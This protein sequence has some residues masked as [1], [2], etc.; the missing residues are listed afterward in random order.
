[1]ARLARHELT[2]VVACYLLAAIA[3]TALLWKDPASRIVAGNPGDPDQAAWW[4]RYAAEAVAHWRLPALITTA[5]NAPDGVNVMW[6]PSLLA[7]GVALSPVTLLF[8]PQV[9]LNVLLTVGFAGSA[10]SLYWVLRQ[11]RVG[12]VAAVVGGLAYGFSPA[13]AQSAVG[14]YDLQFAV[15]PPLIAHFTAWLLTGRAN[16]ERYGPLRTGA[17][18]GLVTALQ[19]LSCEELLFNVVL[20]IAV[21]LV[22]AGVSRVRSVRGWMDREALLGLASG[23]MTAVGVLILIA[24]Y[25]LLTQFAGPLAQHGSFYA[26]DYFKND[27]DGLIQ[28]SRLM[29]VHTRGSVAF[30]DQFGGGPSE[31]LGYLGWPALVVLAWT[32]GALWRVLAARVLAVTFVV[33]EVC[34]LGG[35]LLADG[36]VHNWLKLPWYWVEQLPLASTAI[37]DRFSIIA[38][39]CAA[40]LIALAIDAAWQASATARRRV[41]VRAAIVAAIMVTVV[42]ILPAPLPT[43]SVEAVPLGWSQALADLRL[44]DSAGVL[45][46]PVP[47]DSFP[48]PMRWQAVTGRPASLVG[49]YFIGPVAGGQAYVDAYG[50]DKVLQYLNWLWVQSDATM[51]DTTGIQSSSKVQTPKETATWLA[52]SQVS[53]VVAV[54]SPGSPLADYLTGILGPP[55]AQSGEVMAWRVPLHRLVLTG[56]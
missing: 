27:L 28:P 11:W 55:A 32:A 12:T 45:T 6:N 44:P 23:I 9:S 8:G 14:H 2:V 29:L 24:G 33:L 48:T 19:L 37:V 51:T 56:R 35:M 17:A 21:G 38:D 1:V 34:S 18:L 53:A 47:T 40:A 25:P 5:M 13:L 7:P 50:P 31:Y 16:G 43:A 20:G 10:I 49:G 36:H 22:V 52:S 4:M 46:V 42:P 41:P 3:V 54:A 30:A 15:F 26:I 39:G